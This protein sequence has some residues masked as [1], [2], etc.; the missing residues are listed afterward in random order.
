MESTID[1]ENFF[2]NYEMVDFDKLRQEF[3][4]KEV[5]D[6]NK[7][8]LKIMDLEKLF[9]KVSDHYGD[10]ITILNTLNPTDPKYPDIL[11]D[12][13]FFNKN[14]LEAVPSC[15]CKNYQGLIY[16]GEI[17]PICHTPVLMDVDITEDSILHKSWLEFPIHS[18]GKFIH[19][20]IYKI[21]ANWL[22]Y[23][24]R[25][26][27]SPITY[28]DYVLNPMLNCDIDALK[29]LLDKGRGFEYVYE[30]FDEIISYFANVFPKTMQKTVIKERT[31]ALLALYRDRLF[32]KYLPVLSSTLHA[33]VSSGD[34]N[35][36]K[37][38]NK[39]CKYLLTTVSLLAGL[40]HDLKTRSEKAVDDIIFQAYSCYLDY[41]YDVMYSQLSN[42]AAL[43]RMHIF[44]S[45]LNFTSRGVI[46]PH[47]N[48][49]KMDEIILP[50]TS[51]VELL[52][53]HILGRLI[54][55]YDLSVTEA[56][57]K[58]FKALQVYDPDIHK[59]INDLIKECPYKGLPCLFN[60]NP[61]IHNG[62]ILLVFIVGVDPNV[63]NNTIAMPLAVAPALNADNDGDEMNVY[64]FTEMDAVE[65]YVTLHPAYI[66][67][68]R[69]S[70]E[71]RPEISLAKPAL[72]TLN[73]FLGMV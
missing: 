44:A 58:H 52:K 30:H 25:E 8:I 71:I 22:V 32:T 20:H 29:P 11:K 55:V 16:Q 38:V 40:T 57:N 23:K 42:K 15:Q 9:Y 64:I 10:R 43:P 31:L 63:K 41:Q 61:S 2:D 33:I 62:S 26:G 1:I 60:R 72:V 54:N 73:H 14:I 46:I 13:I 39:N 59:I 18:K 53:T 5:I 34:E 28:L 51:C 24:T 68:G 6:K 12:K 47:S 69:N 48:S 7:R 67:L 65:H 70:P 50:W 3:G 66:M 36:K 56:S 27:R 45:R 49:Y 35:R 37:Y 4:K 21:L 17:C 19:P